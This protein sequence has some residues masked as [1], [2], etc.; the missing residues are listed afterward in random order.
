[1][2]KYSS[3]LT[4]RD[5]QQHDRSSFFSSHCLYAIISDSVMISKTLSM[6]LLLQAV[7][8]KKMSTR[9]CGQIFVLVIDVGKLNFFSLY[10]RLLFKDTRFLRIFFY[11]FLN[12]DW[13]SFS[14]DFYFDWH[15]VEWPTQIEEKRLQI[16]HR[17]IYVCWFWFSRFWRKKKQYTTETNANNNGIYV[18]VILSGESSKSRN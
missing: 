1:M 18:I 17:I 16:C 9:M 13:N 14:N 15:C 5:F 7:T 3:K 12:F 6:Q 10:L 4:L 11:L 2:Q 8:I